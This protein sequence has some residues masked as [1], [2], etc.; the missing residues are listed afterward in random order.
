LNYNCP[1]KTP[2]KARFIGVLFAY[3]SLSAKKHGKQFFY[4]TAISTRF[5]AFLRYYKYMV[6]FAKNNVKRNDKND[7]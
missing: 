3:A 1:P 4:A 6:N 2:Q 7:R 5:R